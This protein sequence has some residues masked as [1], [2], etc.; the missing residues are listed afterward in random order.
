MLHRTSLT[1]HSDFNRILARSNRSYAF[2]NSSHRAESSGE[3]NASV[4]DLG[5]F[6]KNDANRGNLKDIHK[7]AEGGI[8][9]E[10]VYTAYM[11]EVHMFVDVKASDDLDPFTDP[12]NSDIPRG[13][14]FTIDTKRKYL[15]DDDPRVLTLGRNT[16]YAHVVQTRQFRTCVYSISVVGTTARLLRWDRSGVIVTES[17]NYKSEP[18]ILV[19]FV[20]RFSKATKEQRGFDPSAAAATSEEERVQFV[21][22]I[23]KHVEEQLPGLSAEEVWDEVD[24]HLRP[25]AITRLTVGTGAEGRDVLVSQSMFTSKGATRRST[26]GFWGVECESS[27]VVFVKDVWRTNLPETD[28]EGTILKELLEAGVRHIPVP[29]CYGDVVTE[30]ESTLWFQLSWCLVSR[31]KASPKLHRPIGSQ[32][33]T[34]W[35]ASI[36]RTHYAGLS[37]VSTTGWSRGERGSGCQ[38]S[39][40]RG[41]C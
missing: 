33:R 20:W 30:G 39:K 1:P 22:A 19:G 28:T 16:R 12:P 7:R 6:R 23:K 29:V 36:R 3:T 2:Y 27:E 18:E 32:K 11:G 24:R 4:P 26:A 9:G 25:G 31:T 8:P 10:Y 35:K 41:S 5:M 15:E 21:D 14:R 38:L 13:Y 34:G 40:E 37:R 17:F